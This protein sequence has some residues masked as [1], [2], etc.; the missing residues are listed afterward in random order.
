MVI[1]LLGFAQCQQ[2]VSAKDPEGWLPLQAL[3]TKE[4]VLVT[5]ITIEQ[6][7]PPPS[8]TE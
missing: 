2:N 1:S 3:K 8:L 4:L 7:G 5:A 6:A